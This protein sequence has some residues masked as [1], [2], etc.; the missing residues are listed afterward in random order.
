MAD[1]TPTQLAERGIKILRAEFTIGCYD[2][3]AEEAL[4]ALCDYAERTIEARKAG[5][6]KAG[7]KTGAENGKKRAKAQT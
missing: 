6:K 1:K 7:A 4:R 2:D 3:E 5:G